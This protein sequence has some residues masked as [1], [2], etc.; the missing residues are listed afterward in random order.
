MCKE[1]R[2]RRNK[3]GK[4]I[5][6]GTPILWRE[7]KGHDTDCY[8]CMK[9]LK[10]I[11]C[12]NKH[13]VQYLDVPSSMK[14]VPHGTDLSVPGKNV[15]METSSDFESSDMTDY[16]WVWRIETRSGRPTGVSYSDFVSYQ[17]QALS[18][19]NLDFIVN[20]HKKFLLLSQWL[21]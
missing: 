21:I 15:T 3:K 10:R 2:D 7:G 16:R 17:F 8:F 6:F 19:I 5:P 9:N 4:S 18:V 11:N 1:L 14:L 13:H 20:D 12:K